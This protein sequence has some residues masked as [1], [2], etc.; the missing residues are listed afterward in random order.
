M[1]PSS[2]RHARI[3]TAQCQSNATTATSRGTRT[4][5]ILAPRGCLVATTIVGNQ[6]LV[7]LQHSILYSEAIVVFAVYAKGHHR[8]L[9][10]QDLGDAN[11]TGLIQSF[12]S[13]S[14]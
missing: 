14:L 3:G 1:V 11:G 9:C 12:N 8:R 13:L 2:I 4:T 10:T 6:S 7:R 5:R